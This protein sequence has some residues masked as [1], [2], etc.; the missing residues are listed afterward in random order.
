MEKALNYALHFL[1]EEDFYLGAGRHRKAEACGC[2]LQALWRERK[3][4]YKDVI[5]RSDV[6]RQA[7]ASW[8]WPCSSPQRG[9]W[10]RN[11]GNPARCSTGHPSRF[12]MQR[13][14]VISPASIHLH[15]GKVACK[16][17]RLFLLLLFFLKSD[18][19]CMKR[20][21]LATN[22]LACL[23]WYMDENR[24]GELESVFL[25][26]SRLPGPGWCHPEHQNC[27]MWWRET[28]HLNSVSER[29]Y[30]LLCLYIFFW[31]VSNYDQ[32]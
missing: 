24:Q 20:F 5:I 17:T 14:P 30:R 13:R 8:T 32:K 26:S 25:T 2:L 3:G 19:I 31:T 22:Q 12:A 11:A 18:T 7:S 6:S 16:V 15:S 27:P 28:L 10:P 9:G 29:V 21:L 23:S 4:V 1:Q